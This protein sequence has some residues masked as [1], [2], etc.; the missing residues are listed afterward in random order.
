IGAED[1]RF[2]TDHGFDEWYGPLRTYD[3]CMWLEDPHY[4]AERDGYSHMHEGV[5]GKGAWPLKDQQ[6]T[7]KTKETCDLEYQ[8][9]AIKFMEKAVKDDKP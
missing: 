6:L 7:M 9:R 8:R 4:V 5:K 1:G 2:P 3:E